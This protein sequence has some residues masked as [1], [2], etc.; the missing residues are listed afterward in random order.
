MFTRCGVAQCVKRP[1][2]SL[3]S[4]IMSSLNVTNAKFI[5]GFIVLVSSRRPENYITQNMVRGVTCLS[6]A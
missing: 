3:Q 5:V 6:H 2:K 4:V 1:Y